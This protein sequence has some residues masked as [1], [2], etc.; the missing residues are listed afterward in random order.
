[1]PSE[2]T[3]V[4]SIPREMSCTVHSHFP[5]SVLLMSSPAYM[6]TEGKEKPQ[7]CCCSHLS[8]TLGRTD[9]ITVPST[10]AQCLQLHDTKTAPAQAAVVT[11]L[12]PQHQFGITK[13]GQTL[14]SS[15]LSPMPGWPAGACRAQQS[16]EQGWL[17]LP[18]TPSQS[19]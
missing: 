12:C 14:P 18:L 15:Q 2:V 17:Q 16:S 10:P 13:S 1:M 7:C 4:W 8:G 19:P 3:I 9:S 6:H 11:R 5:G